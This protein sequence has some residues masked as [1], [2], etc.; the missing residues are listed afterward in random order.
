MGI[1][2]FNGAAS[3]GNLTKLI[4][5]IK[6]IHWWYEPSD[7]TTFKVFNLEIGKNGKKRAKKV[8]TNVQL[9]ILT[10]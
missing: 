10:T 2:V 3:T 6:I 5:S 4:L 9:V 7:V 8:L 1:T